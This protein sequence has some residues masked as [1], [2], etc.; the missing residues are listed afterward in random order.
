MKFDPQRLRAYMHGFFGYGAWDAPL[1]FVGME[2]GGDSTESGLA[3]R[4]AAWHGTDALADLHTIHQNLRDVPWFG[5]RPMIQRTWGKLIRIALAAAGEEIT[6]ESIRRFQGERLGRAG[7]L[8]EWS[9][10][11]IELFPLPAASVKHW[12]YSAIGLPELTAR[13]T[14]RDHLRGLRIRAIRDRLHASTR[15]PRAIIF[16]GKAYRREWEQI[17][18]H[19]FTREPET[20][21]ETCA[22]ARTLSILTRHPAARGVTNE[23]FDAVGRF[24][25]QR[26]P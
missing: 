6:T 23:E 20:G 2:E 16:Y 7:E 15:A 3:A 9:T 19:S 26:A 12:P 11:L 4:L 5:D 13:D 21:I 10:A 22:S 25:A 17:A 1:W 8:S 18:G 14:Y 24:V